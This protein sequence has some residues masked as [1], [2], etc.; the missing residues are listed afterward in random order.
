M[1]VEEKLGVVV[2]QATKTKQDFVVRGEKELVIVAGV[3]MKKVAP[4]VAMMKEEDKRCH[5]DGD[6]D[7]DDD[8]DGELW[9]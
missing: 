3:T 5:D 6:D 4:V 2:V 7:D 9:S 8:D 1:I